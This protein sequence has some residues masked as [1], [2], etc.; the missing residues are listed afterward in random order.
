MARKKQRK[1]NSDYMSRKMDNKLEQIESRLSALY[2]NADFEVN[3]EFKKFTDTFKLKDES[4]AL[5]VQSG[6][7]TKEEYIRWRNVQILQTDK[8]KAT[9]DHITDVMVKTDLEAMAIVRGEL[10]K[11]MASS[12]NFVQS[13]GWKA[14]DEAGLSM[15]SFQI[16]N[17]RTVQ[18]II[19]ENPQ[20]LPYVDV[21]SDKQWNKNKVNREIT[22]GI[23]KG[24]PINQIAKDLQRVTDMDKNSAIRTARTC[25]TAAENMGRAEA[26][27]DLRD[28]GVPVTEEWSA[29]HDNRTRE[30]HLELDGT[31]RDEN[32]YF[33]ADIL[34]TPLRF[35]ADPLGDPEETYNCRCRLNIKLIGID[36]SQDGE[37]YRKF[38]EGN[39]MDEKE[40]EK[41]EA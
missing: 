2:A 35:P 39:G 6:E 18:K 3:K 5:K 41:E 4:M 16:Y 29:T 22:K 17:A 7:I 11:V 15:G 40:L 13:L 27:E 9:I 24:E 28:K 10:P 19:R 1:Y 30:T 12:Y 8:Y 20:L 21:P 37:L 31:E 23:V 26:A 14:A 38:L 32:G 36:H 25:T 34:D 33:G